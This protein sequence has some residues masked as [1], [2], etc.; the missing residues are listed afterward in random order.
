MGSRSL[1]RRALLLGVWVAAVIS[2]LEIRE[3]GFWLDIVG[4]RAKPA[5]QALPSAPVPRGSTRPGSAPP[6][7]VPSEASAPASGVPPANDAASAGNAG[8]SQQAP[9]EGAAGA[10]G[11]QRLIAPSPE[12]SSA[13]PS[14]GQRSREVSAR[15]ERRSS[16]VRVRQDDVWARVG[17]AW[18]LDAERSYDEAWAVARSLPDRSDDPEILRVRALTALWA[19]QPEARA[20]LGRWLARDP[21]SVEAR[22][23]L[24]QLELRAGDR[25]RARALLAEVSGSPALTFEQRMQIAALQDW[26]RDPSGA[27]AS[28]R[29]ALAERPNDLAALTALARL[30]EADGRP[31]EARD[32]V[33]RGL[34]ISS[35]DTTLLQLDARTS[36][37]AGDRAR[38]SRSYEQVLA[39]R[40][41]DVEARLEA[42]R[43]FVNAGDAARSAGLYQ[44]I[45][46][47]RGATGLRVEIAR[48]SLAAN[49]YPR[50]EQLA[51]EAVASP[52]EDGPQARLALAQS[53]H[54]QGRTSEAN[55]LYDD[56]ARAGEAA[57]LGPAWQGRVALARDQH[58][59]A[60]GLLGDAL[61]SYDLREVG[62][63]AP[64]A[65]D[66]PSVA[67]LWLDRGSAAEKR[68]DYGRAREAYD[69]AD[70]LGAHLASEVAGE[71]LARLT[72]S[73]AEAA[74]VHFSDANRLE[75][76]GG[77]MRSEIWADDRAK[78]ALTAL[79]QVV[80]QHMAK[81]TRTGGALG[82]SDVFLRP[83]LS[84]AG[85]VGFENNSAGGG[86]LVTGRLALRHYF[87]DTS[88]VG[89]TGYRESL[90]TGHE[91]LD[92]RLFNRI[93]N[94]AALGPN[95][96]ING[97]RL[98]LDKALRASAGDRLWVEGGAENYQDGNLRGFVYGHYQLP[99]LSSPGT[100][101]VV[102][103]NAFVETFKR[104]DVPDYFSP[105]THAV[106]GLAAHTIAQSGRFRMEGEA[107]PQLL[108]TNGE[109]GYGGYLLL[110]A[111]VDLGRA[112]VGVSGFGFYDSHD[113][114]WLAHAMAR[115]V[116]PF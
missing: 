21:E 1:G 41:A 67:Q 76:N 78:I 52:D 84:I 33:D 54:L 68:G 110:D 58:L 16:V 25:G 65:S 55:H 75:V 48:A 87:E 77:I 34:A 92:P 13:A 64:A 35:D 4:V 36:A 22:L 90:L 99:I 72:R 112:T 103:P 45:V 50:A 30:L 14:S 7:G 100:W 47:A 83:D 5:S 10:P 81:Y 31:E 17:E 44:Q 32:V 39:Q 80:S 111:S 19:E 105:E 18:Q 38:A 73:N 88:V 20:L 26:A 2:L 59:K 116:V 94:L 85:D 109:A 113:S 104:T 62:S 42:A 8:S 98:L 56:A 102:R 15:A 29:A 107:N 9:V 28:C 53:V 40:P 3:P 93:I 95:F 60:Y 79:A 97:G 74:Y 37:A 106:V 43:Y 115:V 96:A 66:A 46:E 108:V 86:N 11:S 27:I 89:V 91:D 101:A 82:V 69:R 63:S 61:D 114:Y 51:R 57:G 23:A 12:L 49:D 6:A 71:R 24:A 70:G